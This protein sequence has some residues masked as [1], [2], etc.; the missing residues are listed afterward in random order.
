MELSGLLHDLAKLS[1]MFLEK[2]ACDMTETAKDI[3][4]RAIV[5]PKM[6]FGNTSGKETDRLLRDLE[7][8][9]VPFQLMSPDQQAALLQ[10]CF[11]LGDADF[12]VAE[13]LLLWNKGKLREE[14]WTD[15]PKSMTLAR[16]LQEMH[17]ISHHEKEDLGRNE[18]KEGQGDKTR[19][20]PFHK[21]YLATPFGFETIIP[22]DEVEGSLT[23][24]LKR[25][26]IPTGRLE[27]RVKWMEHVQKCLNPGLADTRRPT[28]EVT[29]WD[30]GYTVASFAKPVLSQVTAEC[31]RNDSWDTL[32]WRVLG[33]CLNIP[34][35]L[36]RSGKIGDVLGIKSEI[37]DSFAKLKKWL[38]HECPIANEIYRDETGI[39]FLFPGTYHL[40]PAL[41]D[42]IR[43]VFKE[44]MQPTLVLAADSVQARELDPWK[45]SDLK[46]EVSKLAIIPRKNALKSFEA[47]DVMVDLAALQQQW[48]GVRQER[49]TVCGLRPVAQ[50]R[51]AL[52]RQE[53]ERLSLAEDQHLCPTC[54]G[55]RQTQAAKWL[56]NLETTIWIDEASDD[57]GRSALL[58]GRLGLEGWLDGSA[59]ETIL[60]G[61]T[62]TGE[63]ITKNPSPA[64][65]RRI[66]AATCR[67]WE[68]ALDEDGSK[69]AIP[70]ALG[71]RLKIQG[72]PSASV[73]AN[74]VYELR[75]PAGRSLS[76][77][78]NGSSF[79]TADNL[80]RLALLLGWQPPADLAY[81]AQQRE[82][83]AWL[84]KERLDGRQVTIEEPVGYG[85]KNKKVGTMTVSSATP[86]SD[87]YRPL[88]RILSV[89]M[90][91]Q[92][93]LPADRALE[94]IGRIR[95]KYN[96][97]MGKVRDRLP[98][99][100]GIIFFPR[101]TPL[102]AVIDAGLAMLDGFAQMDT[103]PETWCIKTTNFPPK[104]LDDKSSPE[105]VTLELV[106]D[107]RAFRAK[108]NLC[109]GDDKTPDVWYPHWRLSSDELRRADRLEVG[110]EVQY[111]VSHFDFEFLDATTRRFDI[112]YDS[113]GRRPRVTR[114][115][116]LEDLD[117]LQDIWRGLT[118]G[119]SRTQIRQ[120]VDE[121]EAAREDW[122]GVDPG[123]RS[124][125][126]EVF[127]R[128]VEDTLAGA[129]WGNGGWKQLNASLQ[130]GLIEAGI[131]GELA[132]LTE[133]H[134]MILKVQE[135]DG[136]GKLQKTE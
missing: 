130:A 109:M 52:D 43:A 114:P 42:Q 57:N 68:T 25:L 50:P 134:Y 123:N 105:D 122:F 127:R 5:D 136:D 24:W 8:K 80:V 102:R 135:G 98:L 46:A 2:E 81:E 78:W 88:I 74:H 77:V 89:P 11:S 38:E 39:Y 12:C 20:Q 106:Q 92:A 22:V 13:M 84:S 108:V 1:D 56:H 33:V 104:T 118:G 53:R 29:L 60:V 41:E 133:L 121:V 45:S 110:D 14:W 113:E 62:E 23:W 58:V 112:H 86:L 73:Q 132:D 90:W 95:D 83:L 3:R 44:D 4:L 17:G 79:F 32:T 6:L 103:K 36:T 71:A 61:E 40:S 75:L 100:L 96:R 55:R 72:Q 125:Q 129:E 111:S 35:L 82:V 99:S 131:A 31:W 107:E 115:Y 85:G 66:V 120:V 64:R 116:L 26:S 124:R 54:F 93:V 18:E 49:C 70:L 128:F 117:R 27:D 91:F 76:A 126:D 65:L 30:W 47:P 37:E 16:L 69:P 9:R 15:R 87:L 28:N 59:V 119:L 67:F 21:T 63:K 97:E 19:K 7:K 51:L 101:Y 48:D 94:A 34:E 10:P